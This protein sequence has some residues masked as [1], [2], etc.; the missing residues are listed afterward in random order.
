MNIENNPMNKTSRI[1]GGIVAAVD[2][3]KSGILAAKFKKIAKENECGIGDIKAAYYGYF[4]S[5]RSLITDFMEKFGSALVMVSRDE[6]Y[7][8]N[9]ITHLYDETNVVSLIQNEYPHD[10][11]VK[12]TSRVTIIAQQMFKE[13]SKPNFF[14]EVEHIG[15]ACK[16]YLHKWDVTTESIEKVEIKK[17][18]RVR[19]VL[20]FEPGNHK[21]CKRFVAF[22]YN[23]LQD[24]QQ[25]KVVQEMLGNIILRGTL[26][27]QRSVLFMIGIAGSGKTTLT[28]LM[29]KF[30][31][32]D[33][34]SAIPLADLAG[35][36]KRSQIVGKIVN[37]DADVP[38]TCTIT[39]DIKKVTGGDSVSVRF[40]YINNMPN[41]IINCGH[42]CSANELP[43]SQ[44]NSDGF[45]R[46]FMLVPFNTPI[47][48]SKRIA[49]YELLLYNEEKQHI[50]AWLIKGAERAFRRGYVKK[51]GANKRL[52]SEW[53]NDIEGGVGDWIKRILK[54]SNKC[55]STLSELYMKYISSNVGV[56]APKKDFKSVMDKHFSRKP[57]SDRSIAYFCKCKF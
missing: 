30:I 31:H 52:E 25:V 6:A 29:C 32:P 3:I 37:V 57:K 17:E 53:I 26:Q 21:K 38:R 36:R 50:L 8:Y 10:P 7:Q 1:D 22:L 20:D 12:I 27:S 46:R 4:D 42:L 16:K 55:E 39:G 18:H 15:I 14:N 48:E 24:K 45:Q 2:A 35:D 41:I 33:E 51:R 9:P 11:I 43:L 23:V 28:N 54:K 5:D 34:R 44:D 40:L 19:T 13:Y 47:E 56:K 49:D